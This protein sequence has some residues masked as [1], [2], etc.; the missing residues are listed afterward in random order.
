MTDYN[1]S[2]LRAQLIDKLMEV[3]KL[4]CVYYKLQLE[5]E[6]KQC[7]QEFIDNQAEMFEEMLKYWMKWKEIK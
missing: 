7:K 4:T 1:I 2:G 3:I 5:S 6:D